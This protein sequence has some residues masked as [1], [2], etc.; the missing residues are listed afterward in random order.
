MKKLLTAAFI[1]SFYTAYPQE[2]QS[3]EHFNKILVGPHIELILEEGD[4]ETVLL[5]NLEVDDDYVNVKVKGNTLVI[6]LDDARIT[7]KHRKVNDNGYKMKVPVYEGRMV[8]ATVS[9]KYINKL[10]FRGEE[11]HEV[12]S[13]LDVD[14][15][16]V[17]MYGEGELHIGSIEAETLKVKLYGDNLIQ[18]KEG[19][20]HKQKYKSYGENVIDSKNLQSAIAKSS[21]FGENEIKLQASDKIKFSS[22]GEST[23]KFSGVSRVR[24]G[25]VIGENEIYRVDKSK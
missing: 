14:K 5:S 15:I 7:T 8:T 23:I 9:Y 11:S 3:V 24:K 10:S 22:L 13:T 16:K 19:N 17:K 12:N 4:S 21:N 20:I 6:Y 1:I 2:F 18:I 25:L